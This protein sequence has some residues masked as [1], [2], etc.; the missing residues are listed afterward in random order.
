MNM[1][2]KT[3]TVSKKEFLEFINNYPNPLKRSHIRIC[4]PEMIVYRDDLLP[5]DGEPGS[6]EYFFDKQVATIEMDYRGPNGE[7]DKDNTG[8]YW[9]FEI[10]DSEKN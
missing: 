10:L 3:K 7:L 6:I 8:K 2:Q 9:Q 1:D 5:S 4:D